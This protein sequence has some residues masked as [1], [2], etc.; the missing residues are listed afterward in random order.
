MGGMLLVV[1]GRVPERH[2]AIAHI[3]VDGALAGQDDVGGRREKAVDQA[4]QPLGIGFVEL[5]DAGEPAHVG[6]QQGHVA[7]DA[8]QVELIGILREFLDQGRRHVTAERPAHLIFLGLG[9]QETH[10]GHD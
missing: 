8:A 2:D 9:A 7:H 1:Q 4:D 3:F 5:G 10:Q 6:K